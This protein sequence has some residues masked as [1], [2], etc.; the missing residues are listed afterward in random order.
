MIFDLPGQP[1]LYLA[2][3][4]M[5]MIIKDLTKVYSLNACVVELFDATYIYEITNLVSMIMMSLSSMINLEM[6][7]LN[8]LNKI[9]VIKSII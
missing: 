3:D 9:D 8:L 5:K 1:E 7:H 6:P 4:S 2:H